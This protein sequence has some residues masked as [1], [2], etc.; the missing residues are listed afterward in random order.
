MQREYVLSG[1][2]EK[3]KNG[4]FFCYVGR[5]LSTKLKGDLYFLHIREFTPVKAAKTAVLFHS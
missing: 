2:F 1:R 5:Q 3:V 4:P